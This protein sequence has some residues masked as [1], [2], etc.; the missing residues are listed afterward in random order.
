MLVYQA[1]KAAFMDQVECGVLVEQISE[2]FAERIHRPAPSE[3]ASWQNS[4]QFM[5][6]VLNTDRVPAD[7]GV[8]IEFKIPYSQS[9]IDFMLS[10]RDEDMSESAVIVEL[11][12]WSSLEAVPGKD[13]IVRTFVGRR[14]GEHP[15]PSYQA[16][17]YARM[18]EDYN[19]A[20]RDAEVNLLPCAYLHNYRLSGPDDPLLDPVYAPYLEKA[21]AFTQSDLHKLRDFICSRITRGDDGSVM[22]LIEAGRLRPSKSLQD[23]LSG[24]LAGN[25]EF[26]M[27]DEQKVV[28]ET[29][30]Q[31]ARRARDKGQKSVMI[32]RGGPGTGKSV[33]AVNLLVRA[34]AEELVCQYVSK[35]SAPRNVYSRLLKG[36][37]TRAF[38]NHMFR[39]SN[40][41][42]APEHTFDLLLV[43]EAHRLTRKSDI[44]GNVGENQI[45]E[46][47][48][49]SRATVFFIDEGQRVTL[50]DI[51]AI[52]DIKR[53]AEAAGAKV[54]EAELASQFRC[55]GSESY[56][57]WLDWL[58]GVSSE[59]IDAGERLDYDFEVFDDPCELWSE[60]AQR[61]CVNNK[62][63]VLAGYCW[64]WESAGRSNPTHADIVI[65]DTA[66][67]R[68]WNL[69]STGT[70]AI[71]EGSI[72]QI[73]CIHTAQGLEFEY[74][75]VIVGDDLR[76][77]NGAVITDYT[78]RAKMDQ[79]LRGVKKLAKEDPA[80]A[81]RLADELIRN[82]YRVLMT[83]GMKGCYVY[84]TDAPLRQ[85][86]REQLAM[87]T[88]RSAYAPS[89]RRPLFLAA[90]DPLEAS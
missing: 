42:D 55:N 72:D 87:A 22:Y 36:H 74:A 44:Y 37:H 32:V 39:G 61:N 14:D 48:A 11:K 76:Y 45:K 88:A 58:L 5:Y 73:G 89:E 15:H 66:F 59:P 53:L 29:A 6:T 68:S 56:L 18:I 31:L 70:W 60:I 71:D 27:I 34:T 78:K 41:V 81:Q 40:L 33:V 3:V 20:V 9:R 23:A 57:G 19:E 84:C 16:W 8:A 13:G 28:F 1:D 25:D 35:N 12:Q 62:S 79:S 10:G 24:M 49:A 85:H 63:R 17:S 65:P 77:E 30:M 26:V 54:V 7:C 52:D 86:L 51:G 80:R 64:E 4:M 82:T 43:D 83:R 21:P 46:I 50:K 90:D 75:G 67:A 69:G 2:A 38:I 47:I